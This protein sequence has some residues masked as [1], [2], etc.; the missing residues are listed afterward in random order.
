M[1]IRLTKLQRIIKDGIRKRQK[2]FD[3]VFKK[4]HLNDLN[5]MG[6]EIFQNLQEKKLLLPT[7]F[8]IFGFDL[9]GKLDDY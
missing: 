5:K 2:G 1:I 3:V 6:N 4:I 9:L 8:T 7:N